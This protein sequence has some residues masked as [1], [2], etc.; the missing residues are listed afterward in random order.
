[1]VPKTTPQ[2]FVF[3]LLQGSLQ[4]SNRISQGLGCGVKAPKGE[5]SF[6]KW[7]GICGVTQEGASWRRQVEASAEVRR[8]QVGAS[9]EVRRRQV[10]VSVEVRR[11]QVGASAGV[12]K[13]QVEVSV[14]VSVEVGR[15]QVKG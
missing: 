11:C 1:M 8:R 4:R 9:V 5:G 6:G 15:R 10:G 13:H 3:C 12:R 14:E 7:A 2:G